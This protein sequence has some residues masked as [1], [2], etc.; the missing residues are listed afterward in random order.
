MVKILQS[1]VELSLSKSEETAAPSKTFTVEFKS[2]ENFLDLFLLSTVLTYKGLRFELEHV[3]NA[4]T[5]TLS[6][7]KLSSIVLSVNTVEYS[8]DDIDYFHKDETADLIAEVVALIHRHLD[9]ETF[10]DDSVSRIDCVLDMVGSRALKVGEACLKTPVML[11]QFLKPNVDSYSITRALDGNI[12]IETPYK[13]SIKVTNPNPFAP[14]VADQGVLQW[15][16]YTS[17]D[18]TYEDS[19]C[20]SSKESDSIWKKYLTLSGD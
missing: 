2:F 9:D 18:S 20:T 7:N 6:P 17:L 15:T 12:I 11:N 19:V 3:G 1:N 4:R 10:C 5:L 14:T 16:F 8:T 13:T